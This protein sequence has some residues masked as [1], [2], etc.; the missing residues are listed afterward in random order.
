MGEEPWD[1]DHCRVGFGKL[2]R[3]AVDLYTLKNQNGLS[4]QITDYGATVTAVWVPDREGELDDIVLGFATLEGYLANTAFLGATVGRFANR[5]RDAQFELD[6]RRYTLAANDPPHHLHGGERGFDKVLWR[7]EPFESQEGSGL[8][9]S[10]TSKAGEEGY[11]GTVQAVTRYVLTHANELKVDMEATTD[12]P[13]LVNLAH[14]TYWNLAGKAAPPILDHELTLYASNFTPGDPVVP[15]GVV[16]PVHGT[17]FDFTTGKPIGRDLKAVGGKPIGYD[18]NFVVDG[19]PSALRPV[20]RVRHPA[21][22]RV[23]TLQANQPGLQF[24]SGNF[25]DG[26]LQG[27][28]GPYLQYTGF[29]LETQKF[30]NSINVPAWRDEVILRPGMTYRHSMVHHF[31]VE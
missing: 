16:Q 25:L 12:Q 2:G 31:S 28:A 14:H 22:G 5:I 11:P 8:R 24:Y 18:H 23:L 9:L 27:K 26:S 21:S 29:C 3:T 20:A 4:V 30:P 17:P 10:Y 6:G 19:E 1:P 13:T 15:T 7:A